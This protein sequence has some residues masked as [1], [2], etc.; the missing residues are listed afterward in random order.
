MSGFA[1]RSFNSMP[2]KS[3][4]LGSYA[5]KKTIWPLELSNVAL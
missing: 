4:A 5:S 1:A 3:V 2:E